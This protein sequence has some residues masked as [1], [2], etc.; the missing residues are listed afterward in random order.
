MKKMNVHWIFWVILAVALIAAIVWMIPKSSDV[1]GNTSG[2]KIDSDCVK[3]SCCHATSC[4]GNENAPNCGDIMCTQ[5][6][7]PNTLDCGQGSCACDAGTCGV[8]LK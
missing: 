8:K 3:A 5:E 7:V 6:C 1:N 4:V 2:C